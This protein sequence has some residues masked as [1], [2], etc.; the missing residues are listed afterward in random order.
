MCWCSRLE[1]VV[2]FRAD[3]VCSFSFLK[4]A[5]KRRR[6]AKRVGFSADDCCV[7]VQSLVMS[8]Y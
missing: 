6:D 2:G 5:I 3:F 8:E 4:R 1:F 7:D